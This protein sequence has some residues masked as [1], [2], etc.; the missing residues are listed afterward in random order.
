MILRARLSFITNIEPRSLIK[1]FRTAEFKLQTDANQI[2][3]QCT[4]VGH[5]PARFQYAKSSLLL[6]EE[7]RDA[8]LSARWTYHDNLA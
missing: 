4:I 3:V 5:T 8:S 1:T 2:A 6:D 7:I